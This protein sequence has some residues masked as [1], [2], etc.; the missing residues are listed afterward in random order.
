MFGEY[1]AVSI[2]ITKKLS[3]DNGSA[4]Y[5]TPNNVNAI[6]VKGSFLFL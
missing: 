2:S 4:I 1:T 3:K 6:F 5:T